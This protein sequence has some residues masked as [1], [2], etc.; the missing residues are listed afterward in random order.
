MQEFNF[1]SLDK[2]QRATLINALTGFKSPFLISS[3]DQDSNDNLS[4][5]SN[6]FHLGANPSLIGIIFRP[7]TVPRD[8]LEN[9][10]EKKLFGLNAITQDM[11]K[12]AHQTSARYPK[13]LSEFDAC[14]FERDHLLEN[15]PAFVKDSPLKMAMKY[16]N[17]YQ[18]VENNTHLVVSELQHLFTSKKVKILEDGCLELE[19]AHLIASLGLDQY[20]TTDKLCRFSYAKADQDLKEI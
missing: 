20:F 2:R 17:E 7:D 3:H 11:L 8:T 5:F 4:I 16:I 9:I 1:K 10:R 6:I 13:A 18:I 15:Y 12:K 14:H 19:A